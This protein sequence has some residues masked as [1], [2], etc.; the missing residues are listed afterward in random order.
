MSAIAHHPP[1]CCTIRDAKQFTVLENQAPPI[2]KAEDPTPGYTLGTDDHWPDQG[3][4]RLLAALDRY[5]VG[6]LCEIECLEMLIYLSARR[7][8]ARQLAERA[9]HRYGSLANVFARPGAELRE[10]LGFDNITTSMLAIAKTS[11]KYILEPTLTPRREL[12][13]YADLMNYLS[14][15]LR[16]AEQEILRVIYLD[17][18]HKII[19]DEE[20][21][22]G[23]VQAVPIYPKEVAKRALLYCASSVI[24][25][26]NHLSDDPTPSHADIEV[27]NKTKRALENFDI[28]LND[29][30]IIAR[31]RC[32]SMQQIGLV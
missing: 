3:L 29:H 7:G 14:L 19:R 24:L 11:M 5:N 17:A 4:N 20:V 28:V 13:S 15:D 21:A 22:R 32:L 1:S 30:V 16:E 26:H 25:V 23:T 10:V 9:I 18:K 12:P 8:D 2:A 27:T 31:S 6:S